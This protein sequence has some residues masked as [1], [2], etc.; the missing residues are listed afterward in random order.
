MEQGIDV[1]ELLR[2]FN[3]YLVS[4]GFCTADSIGVGYVNFLQNLFMPVDKIAVVNAM[5]SVLLQHAMSQVGLLRGLSPS[6][7]DEVYLAD[8]ME[9]LVEKCSNFVPSRVGEDED[10]NVYETVSDYAIDFNCPFIQLL[11]TSRQY[12]KICK[13]YDDVL[14]SGD[15]SP[16]IMSYKKRFVRKAYEKSIYQFL[17]LFFI[18]KDLYLD[19]VIGGEAIFQENFLDN[20]NEIAKNVS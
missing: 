19:Y 12:Y 8:Y 16:L 4:S 11:D 2:T 5:D 6:P 9:K 1:D 13:I 7:L 17:V 10:G 15:L 20:V 18:S 14:I 3:T